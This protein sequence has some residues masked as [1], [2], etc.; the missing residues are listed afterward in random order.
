LNA[1]GIAANQTL[2]L[3]LSESDRVAKTIVERNPKAPV[4]RKL[5]AE[6]KDYAATQKTIALAHC[7]LVNC[8]SV[9]DRRGNGANQF[10][11]GNPSMRGFLDL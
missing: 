3:P 4:P 8:L 9:F 7:L 1:A 2:Q 11:S 5:G 6:I 10:G